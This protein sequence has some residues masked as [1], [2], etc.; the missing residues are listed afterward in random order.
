MLAVSTAGA[1]LIAEPHSL[2][3]DTVTPLIDLSIS[4]NSC[5][6]ANG[7]TVYLSSDEAIYRYD[8]VA[9][10]LD[11]VMSLAEPNSR[12]LVKDGSSLI[13]SDGRKVHV[14]DVK[15]KTTQTL[16]SHTSVISSI[17]LSNDASLLASATSAV[18]HVYNLATGSN[19]VLRGLALAGQSIGACAFHSH[20]RTR[21][22]LGIGRQ[23]VVYDT[24]RPSSPVKTIPLDTS[25]S[26]DINA[27]SSSPFSKSL[28]AV[29]TTGGYLGLIDLEKEKGL[30]RTLN[31]GVAVPSMSF[32]QDGASVYLGT[33]DGR[34]LVVDLRA[35]EKPPK[36]VTVNPDSK[37]IT[38]IAIQSKSQAQ[39]ALK[40]D[41]VASTSKVT[42][43]SR[44]AISHKTT[45][46]S[47]SKPLSSKKSK[48]PAMVD[49]KACS[50]PEETKGLNDSQISVQLETL[51]AFKAPSKSKVST[52]KA[53]S[54]KVS[55]AKTLTSLGS[56]SR[57]T[58][59]AR[60]AKVSSPSKLSKDG[61]RKPRTM[62]TGSRAR[63]PAE[64]LP[65]SSSQLSVPSEQDSR[66][67][68]RQSVI[69]SASRTVSS[70]STTGP[71]TGSR[72]SSMTSA[73]SASSLSSRITSSAT[74]SKQTRKVSRTS[75]RMTSRTPSP[76]LPGVTADPAT[77]IPAARKRA[78]L[79]VLGLGTPE[80]NRWI[81]AGN[82]G[83]E[84]EA[85]KDKGK[86]KAVGF[87]ETLDTF[88]DGDEG[89]DDKENECSLVI[90][91][92]RRG[93]PAQHDWAAASP[94]RFAMPSSPGVPT[95]GPA[96]ELLRT[97]VKDVMC[98]FQQESRNE[99]V[100]LHLDMLRMGRNWK[101]DMKEMMEYMGSL[102]ALQEENLRLREENER[103]RRGY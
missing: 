16:E 70:T 6:W 95:T 27:I 45:P 40:K 75:T 3:R 30:F 65:S 31:L 29:S 103:L 35:L 101:K 98:D 86:G 36:E 11:P 8:C 7:S 25:S 32:S 52:T 99:M 76:D 19:S 41:K 64:N 26:G 17:S 54:P 53:D 28:V 62:P 71:S 39:E 68:S 9:G 38:A 83:G 21:L 78:A 22:L 49:A 47:P 79:G 80:V 42:T 66:P 55:K 94:T 72:V 88:E 51:S 13:V 34:L 87:Q 73:R 100:G 4:P 67:R 46:K 57:T 69:S 5:A 96:H 60:P 90:S 14:V 58:A 37:P 50:Q 61:P 44:G 84:A 1:L 93:K 56:P 89:E 48:T 82:G 91:P 18:V 74:S 92:L 10:S 77:P 43:S 12:V 85:R 2:K 59:S 63:L 33:C 20:S 15:G 81:E 102:K 24:T 23:F 97:I